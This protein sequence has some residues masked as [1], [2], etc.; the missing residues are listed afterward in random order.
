LVQLLEELGVD[1]D[2]ENVYRCMLGRREWGVSR[3]AGA[4]GISETRVRAA[5][6]RLGDLAL[7]RRSVGHPDQVRPVSPEVGLQLQLHRQQLQLLDQQRKFTQSQAAISRLISDYADDCSAGN[8]EYLEGIDAVHTRLERLSQQAR[9]ECLSLMPGGAQSAQSLDASR[10]LDQAMLARDVIVSTVYLDS[11][12]NDTPTLEYAR[13]LSDHGG[14]VRTT[15]VLPVRMVVFD[16]QAALLP[17]DPDDTRLGAVQVTGKGL[18]AAL[19]A[20]FAQLWESATPLG[21]G[22]RPGGAGLTGP[23]RELLRLLAQ[24]LTDEVA[25]R[26]LGVSLRTVRRM[27]S[28]LMERLGA[29]SRF[30]AGLHVAQRGW[31]AD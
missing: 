11:I 27:M 25:A 14:A 29:R 6:D 7:L 24:G 2:A 20:L 26:Q 5:L 18:I 1:Q 28:G 21:E 13:W 30:E 12:R 31:L 17:L 15:P 8:E 10:P 9:G 3:I 16:R 19:A 23:E 4:L 22:T